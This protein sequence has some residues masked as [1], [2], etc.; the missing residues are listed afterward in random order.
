MDFLRKT[1][2]MSYPAA[3]MAVFVPAYV[4]ALVTVK[5]NDDSMENVL[6]RTM[7][8]LGAVLVYMT[9]VFVLSRILKRMDVVDAA[10]GGG[11]IVAAIASFSLNNTGLTIGFNAQTLV[12]ALVIA[13]G[14][15]LAYYIIKRL[16]KHPEDKRYV[17][18]RKQWKGNAALN[19]YTRIFL[20]QGILATVISIAVIH[21]NFSP[22]QAIGPIVYIGAAI[23][24][25]GFIFESIGDAQLKA[26]IANPANKGKLMTKGLWKY[27]RHPNY[28]GEST[29]WWGI[30]VIGLSTMYGWIGIVTP[31]VITY[32]L[33]F[34]SG[35]KMS[36][37]RFEGRRG[38]AAYKKRTS[39]FVPLPPS[40][41]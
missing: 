35:V 10:W 2:Q 6:G 7:L 23:W 31:V 41:K 17:D 3:F 37:K 12:T 33:L 28:F 36:E 9:I 34:V 20:T 14:G 13:W 25:F 16:L 5:M 38:W 22:E 11:F 15:R 21:I 24:L 30:F 1:P 26:F 8:V 19:S 29:M 40:S 4:A 32:L 39:I 27:T 18:L